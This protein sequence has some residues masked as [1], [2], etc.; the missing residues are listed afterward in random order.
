MLKSESATFLLISLRF[1]FFS[2][3]KDILNSEVIGTCIG[4]RTFDKRLITSC[5]S[6]LGVENKFDKMDS[7]YLPTCI[8]EFMCFCCLF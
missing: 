5:S 8:T 3:T 6:F 1:T 4:S 7:S 2:C